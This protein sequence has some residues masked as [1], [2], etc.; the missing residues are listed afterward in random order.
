[1]LKEL[2]TRIC[3]CNDVKVKVIEFRDKREELVDDLGQKKVHTTCANHL[4]PKNPKHKC[5]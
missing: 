4:N 1:M 5:T 3:W 2:D